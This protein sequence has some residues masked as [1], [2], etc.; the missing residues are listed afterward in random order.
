MLVNQEMTVNNKQIAL[1][2][3]AED[4]WNRMEVF[5]DVEK[6]VYNYTNVRIRGEMKREIV[7]DPDEVHWVWYG[8]ELDVNRFTWIHFRIEAMPKVGNNVTV[9]AKVLVLGG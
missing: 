7:K 1:F 4:K 6:P 3:L 2:A 5:A 9:H 8:R